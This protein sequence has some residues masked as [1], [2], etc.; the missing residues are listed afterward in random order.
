MSPRG[1][2]EPRVRS[3]TG[4]LA[5]RPGRAGDMF[6][7]AAVSE[8][9]VAGVVEAA[10]EDT[11][12]ELLMETLTSPATLE[13]AW[14]T[15]LARDAR[16][17]ELKRQ[18]EEIASDLDRVLA[19]LAEQLRDGTYAPAP[20]ARVRI[21]KRVE[22]EDRVL[23]VPAV[24]DRIVERAVVDVLGQRVDALMS[25]CSFGYR[26]GLGVD[27]A[28]EHLVG[29]RDLGLGLVLRTDIKDFFPHVRLEG[30]LEML[31]QA[32]PSRRVLALVAVLASPRPSWRS[33]R[34]RS[35]G[36]AQGSCLSPMLA[37]LSFT[38][39]DEVV[40]RS[41]LGYVRFADDIVVCADT[42]DRLLWAVDLL[43]G[44]AAR[45]GL[46][47]NEEK[48]IVTSFD[49]G[50]CYLGVD[51]G[52]TYPRADPHHDVA[53]GG[54]D[55]VVYV[56]RDGARVSVTKDRLVVE[57]ERM[58]PYLSVPRR[59]V[60]RIVLTGAV[61]LSAG[62][63]SWALFND[64][65]VVLLS[66]RG[67]YLGQLSGKRSDLAARRLLAQCRHAED[68][69]QR[70]PL[71]RA[72]VAAKMR[73]QL[74]LLQR[75][76]RRSDEVDLGAAMD[77][78]RAALADVPHTG[79]SDEL[80]GLEGTASAAYFHVLGALVPPEVRFDGR[81]RRPPLDVANAA[82]SYGYALLLGECTA[83]LYAA[84]LEPSLGVLHASTDRRPSLALDLMEEF[85]PLLVDR[86]VL[87]LLRT[88]RLRA[89]H[90]GPAPEE[91]Q[92]G[93]DGGGV[94]LTSVGKK[95]LVD[96]YEAALQR[97]VSGALPGFAGTWRRHLHHQA[98]RLGRAIMDPGYEWSGTSWR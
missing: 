58:V 77:G 31:A 4:W 83:A 93:A 43:G 84:G 90:G 30:A 85:R 68:D 80:M 27:D 73:N 63:R 78:V 18:T 15:V 38:S 64:V 33:R 70:L 95:V 92:R 44:A 16:D 2:H 26:V 53:D 49:E 34:V 96:G 11:S 94:W 57:S 52:G 32:V 75:T 61:G 37:N 24:R 41:G 48:S 36:L 62:A 14:R 98:Q 55:Q 1:R 28:V 20:L 82:L 29:L 89:E 72:L 59:A 40:S 8:I 51:L 88:R 74:R 3:D 56:G 39:V 97:Q 10:P 45:I 50:F 91:A 65:D 17:G 25:P 19:D 22:G 60:R 67:T 69:A 35:G 81:S 21:P 79:T 86:T 13:A 12:G 46:G 76:A 42:E 7:G 87:T 71:A 9:R 5:T 47:L 66:R 23:E 6:M 54:P